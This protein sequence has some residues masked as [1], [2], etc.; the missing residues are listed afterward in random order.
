M[1]N[2]IF[3]G[4]SK[5]RMLA[6]IGGL[7]LVFCSMATTAQAT[8]TDSVKGPQ[9]LQP[10]P[11]GLSVSGAASGINTDYFEEA[12]IEAITASHIFSAIDSG[13]TAEIV[14][15]MI[16]AKGVFPGE[17]TIDGTP[18]LLKI[19][20]IRVEAPSFS[21][22]MTVSM[23][24]VWTL[25]RTDGEETLMHEVIHSTY[26]GGAFEGGIIGANRVRAGTEGAVREN[27]RIGLEKLEALDLE[28][29]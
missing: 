8:L 23:N 25:Y 7:T 2:V 17:S 10:G 14:M 11:L 12:A 27:I 1:N 29:G 24:V 28:Q 22:K 20:V 9:A 26:T 18:Y 21:I 6:F 15:P 4:A 3:N 13:E 16:R 19:R 5:R